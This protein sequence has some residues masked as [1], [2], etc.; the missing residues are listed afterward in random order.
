MVRLSPP[1]THPARCVRLSHDNTEIL[2]C[3]ADSRV[4]LWDWKSRTPIRIY[5]GHFISIGC[6]DLASQVRVGGVCL[7]AT[8]PHRCV[9]GGGGAVCKGESGEESATPVAWRPCFVHLLVAL[10]L[11]AAMLLCGS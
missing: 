2:S 3:G 1:H 7:C 10:M 6:C 4:V 9:G 8:W 11:C 5:T